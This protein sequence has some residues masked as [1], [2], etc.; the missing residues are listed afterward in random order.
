MGMVETKAA[1]VVEKAVD[2]W[3]T[4]QTMALTI[5][6]PPSTKKSKEKEEVEERATQT[7]TIQTK[8]TLQ[9]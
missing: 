7:E 3:P 5:S 6:S 1:L 9:T 8:E 2:P 4:S